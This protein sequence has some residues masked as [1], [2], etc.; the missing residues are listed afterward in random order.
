M[1]GSDLRINFMHNN[2]TNKNCSIKAGFQVLM[3][4][5]R[6]ITPILCAIW[7]LQVNVQFCLRGA[8]ELHTNIQLGFWV[9]AELHL[10][11]TAV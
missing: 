9:T 6:N 11:D 4:R 8:A 10:Q 5:V 2:L 7:H 1:V 3:A